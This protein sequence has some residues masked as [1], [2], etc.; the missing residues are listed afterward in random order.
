MVGRTLSFRA[1]VERRLTAV[2]ARLRIRFW[3]NVLLFQAGWF[4]CVLGA[5]RGEAWIAA[6]AAAAVLAWHAANARSPGREVALAALATGVGIVF[7]SA[8][9][10]LGIIEASSGILVPGL[11]AYWLVC[12]W[13]L[14]ATTFNVSLRWLHGRPLLAAALGAVGG[15]LA[16]LAGARLGALQLDTGIAALA[17]LASG[18]ALAMVGLMWAARRLDGYGTA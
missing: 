17:A 18:W 4:A 12:M 14:F 8:M 13:A 16:Y 15:P 7:E 6:L 5:A 1:P 10:R 2:P 9:A 3:L 11:A